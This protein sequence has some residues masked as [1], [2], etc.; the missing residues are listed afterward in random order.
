MKIVENLFTRMITL[1]TMLCSMASWSDL[2]APVAGNAGVSKAIRDERGDQMT[3]FLIVLLIVV[4]AGATF[5][6]IYTGGIQAIWTALQ[7]K[8]TDMINGI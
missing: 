1:L 4:A 2:L 7:T 3:S 6:A 5:M 8:I